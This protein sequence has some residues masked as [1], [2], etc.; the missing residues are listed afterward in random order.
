MN[1]TNKNKKRKVE[2]SINEDKV[3]EKDGNNNNK[4][5]KQRPNVDISD[6]I[7]LFANEIMI[8]NVIRILDTN[9]MK[10]NDEAVDLLGN[11]IVY[12]DIIKGI[13]KNVKKENVVWISCLSFKQS[14][15]NC[16]DRVSFLKKIGLKKCIEDEPLMKTKKYIFIPINNGGHWSIL[17]YDRDMDKYYHYDSIPFSYH[18]EYVNECVT[19]MIDWKVFSDSK[20]G[21]IIRPTFIPDQPSG[22]ECGYYLLYFAMYISAKDPF[23]PLSDVDVV[24]RKLD[25][26]HETRNN[27]FREY[28]IGILK[29]MKEIVRARKE[30]ETKRNKK[31]DN[32]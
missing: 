27:R 21:Q 31:K 32:K 11:I 28:F 24:F 4:K 16:H 17:Y 23:R 29:R 3:K 1:T 20:G 6:H 13:I 30:E 19:N 18:R 22:W 10:L 15:I 26:V 14:M 5:K 8:N 7:P 12:S 2:V 25:R 9:E